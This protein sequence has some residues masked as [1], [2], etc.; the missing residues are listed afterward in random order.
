MNKTR[1]L[2][3]RVLGSSSVIFSMLSLMF[4]LNQA[5]TINKKTLVSAFNEQKIHSQKAGAPSLQWG[6][7]HATPFRRSVRRHFVFFRHRRDFIFFLF[8]HKQPITALVKMDYFCGP[9]SVRI[10]GVW[11]YYYLKSLVGLF[12]TWT[13]ICTTCVEVSITIKKS[14]VLSVEDNTLTG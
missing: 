7:K 4:V 8:G 14:C 12:V 5:K 9:L 13:D 11:L 1:T 6:I 3:D 2:R 10:H